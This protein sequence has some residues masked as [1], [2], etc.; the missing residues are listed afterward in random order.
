MLVR[1]V[2]FLVLALLA[3]VPSL[4]IADWQGTEARRVQIAAEMLQSGDWLVPQL[5]QE[6]TFAK[7]PLHYWLLA[8]VEHVFGR[9]FV[10]ARLPSVLAW[11]LLALLGCQLV[12]RQFGR[13]A[14]WVAGLGVLCAPV[15]LVQMPSAEID[16]LFASC[17][18]GSILC[19]AAGVAQ[20]RRLV[21]LGSGLLGGLALLQKGPPFF[22]FAAGAYLVWWRHRGARH[23]L[24]HFV[25][26]L[27][28]PLVWLVP[29]LLRA[30][31]AELLQTTGEESIGRMFLFE[32]RHVLETPLFWLRAFAVQ[33]PL[34][35]WCFWE[36]RGNRDARMG[37]ADL[38]LRMCS[39][40]AV[41]AV[42]LLTFFPARPTR[43][44]LPNIAIFTFAVAPAVAHFAAQQREL[45]R[46]SGQ[47][48]RWL[49]VAAAVALI[50]VPLTPVGEPAPWL[51]LLAVVAL[52]PRLVRTPRQLVA[53]CLWLPL[54]GIWTIGLDR[55]RD[56]VDSRRARVVHGPLLRSELEQRGALVGLATFGHC[57]SGV[58][59]GAQ[60]FPPGDEFARRP[61]T[62][63]WLLSEAIS[64]VPPPPRT[65]YQPR[66][67]LCMPGQTFVLEERVEGR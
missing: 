54:L 50:V 28:V 24:L 3:A 12:G 27:L 45:G 52:L 67:R 48:L 23:A 18:A 43:Y 46:F 35:L 37:D 13:G 44:L 17:T 26:L 66:L 20:G 33:L 38:Q 49:A 7:P 16:P 4:S 2:C 65:G 63:R 39:G 30:S 36:W 29:L 32:P 34:V 8:V 1:A 19:L 21:V 58:L 64:D 42:V 40:A 25:P 59:L 14:G 53:C 11:W 22:L 61:P 9:G 5:G 41:L 60:L 62:A 55:A 51:A 10:A 6:P 31:P 47:L 15:H 56:Y 57:H